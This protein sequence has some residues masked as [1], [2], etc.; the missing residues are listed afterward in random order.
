MS[1]LLSLATA[2][3]YGVAD[4]SGGLASRKMALWGV[5]AWS[6][7]IGV[8]LLGLTLILIDA[9][10]ISTGDIALGAVAGVLGLLGIASLYAALARGSMSIVSPIT[11]SLAALL[12]V[13]AGLVLGEL[14]STQQWVGVGCALAAV[15]L[16]AWDRSA[17][18][19]PASVIGLSVLA[20]V[21]FAAFFILLDQTSADSG[22][23]PL[24]AARSVSV[25][26]AFVVAFLRK[27]AAPPRR[28]ILPIVAFAGLADM[29]ANVTILLALQ[30]GPLGV[31]AV[32]ASLY[33]AFT[34]LA[35]ILILK[36]HPNK[37]QWLGIGMALIAVVL[38]AV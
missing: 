8:A 2:A 13:A 36:E 7:L 16:V 29:A 24:V 35:A 3:L 23:W 14:L 31:S 32:I 25:P 30:S 19:A 22:I 12:P 34:V 4:F 1:Q 27:S 15:I 37:L 21:W 17:S 6:Q 26:L 9:P 38:L 20:A 10:A 18:H 28:D 11:G 5:V 33:P